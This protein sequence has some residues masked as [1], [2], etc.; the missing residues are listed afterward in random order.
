MIVC[1]LGTCVYCSGGAGDRRQK[2]TYQAV[3]VMSMV[4]FCTGEGASQGS[5][6]DVQSV[7]G[8]CLICLPVGIF[9]CSTLIRAPV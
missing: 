9:D 7:T 3:V 6:G 2:V 8:E 5:V 1:G 4:I